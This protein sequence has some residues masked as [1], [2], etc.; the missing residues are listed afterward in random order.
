[1]HSHKAREVWSTTYTAGNICEKEREPSSPCTGAHHTGM[2]KQGTECVLFV[3]TL[4]VCCFVSAL[5]VQWGA[6]NFRYEDY[7]PNIFTNELYFS[8]N[9]LSSCAS[10]FRTYFGNYVCLH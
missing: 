5:M 7:F 4:F 8:F 10:I 1:M 9:T 2:V 3:S 6:C